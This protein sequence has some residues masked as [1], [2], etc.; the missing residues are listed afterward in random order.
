MLANIIKRVDQNSEIY[1]FGSVLSNNYNMS[2]Y[3]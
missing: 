2:S 1:L 3:C